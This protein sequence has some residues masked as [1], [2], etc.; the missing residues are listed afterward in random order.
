MDAET[1]EDEDEHGQF[2]H[3]DDDDAPTRAAAAVAVAGTRPTSLMTGWGL[4]AIRFH[5]AEVHD[6]RCAKSA[7]N[8]EQVRV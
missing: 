4:R 7:E 5:E 3:D 8:R 6:L 2:V 1:S